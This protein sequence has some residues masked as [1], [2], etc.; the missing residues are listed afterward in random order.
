MSKTELN[1]KIQTRADKDGL[2]ANHELRLL[3]EA[4]DTATVGFYSEPQTVSV[5][6]FMGCW[7][8]AR[9]AWSDYSG[10]PLV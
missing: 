1:L 7:A 10:E 3:G 5:K 4:L 2:A 9:K 6:K 8:R